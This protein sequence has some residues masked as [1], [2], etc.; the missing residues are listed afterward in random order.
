MELSEFFRLVAKA[1]NMNIVLHPAVQGKV[2]VNVV[3]YVVFLEEWFSSISLVS[4]DEHRPYSVSRY[5][6]GRA[7]HVEQ[8]VDADDDRDSFRRHTD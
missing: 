4:G 5:I 3:A 2:N 7:A 6:H 8:T 1:A